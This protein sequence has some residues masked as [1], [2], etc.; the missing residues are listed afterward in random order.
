MRRIKSTKIVTHPA[1]PWVAKTK[2]E[3]IR[4]LKQ[5][6][7]KILKSGQADLVITIGGDGTLLYNKSNAR[8]PIFAIGSKQSHIC[9][10][11]KEEWNGKLL[12]VLNGKYR[13]EKRSMLTCEIEGRA[14]KD[15]LNEI[16]IRSRDHRVIDLH[17]EVGSKPYNFLADGVLFSTPTGSTAYC[18]SAG[19]KILPLHARKFEI[20]AIAP[21]KRLF[22]PTAVSDTAVVR[23]TTRSRTADLV[24]DG[25][26]IH[27]IPAGERIRIYRSKNFVQLVVV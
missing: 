26:F 22:K 24:F 13:I 3:V 15:A 2:A 4:F 19:G 9:Q 17:L 21:Y 20:V 1:K 27:R 23:A 14:A 16:V 11:R 6:G 10:A 7:V 18:Y 5:R 12:R 25:Q 8:A